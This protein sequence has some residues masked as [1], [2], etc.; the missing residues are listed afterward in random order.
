MVVQSST[1]VPYCSTDQIWFVQQDQSMNLLVK[2]V[3]A[4]NIHFPPRG[5]QKIQRTHVITNSEKLTDFRSNHP[6]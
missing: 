2:S 3:K 1:V 5:G 6:S 4:S